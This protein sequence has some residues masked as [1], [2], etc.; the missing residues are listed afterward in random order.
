MSGLPCGH[1]RRLERTAVPAEA[2]RPAGARE[3]GRRPASGLERRTEAVQHLA[4]HTA[5]HLPAVPSPLQ[6]P[7]PLQFLE[8]VRDGGRGDLQLVG[9]L[10]H[11]TAR[12][13]EAAVGGPGLLAAVPFV[14]DQESNEPQPMRVPECFEGFAEISSHAECAGSSLVRLF[15]SYQYIGVGRNTAQG[16]EG[17][18]ST[19]P[20]RGTTTRRASR[21]AEETGELEPHG[22]SLWHAYRRRWAT[23]RKH[24]PATDIAEAGGRAGPETLQEAY[25]QAGRDTMLEVVTGGGKLR[26]VGG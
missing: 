3:S 20:R 19:E 5:E 12:R 1:L 18:G 22:G 17:L 7:R 16:R 4:V 26:E 9:Q 24:L 14:L 25:R 8:V 6:Q 10:S 21:Q 11:V 13:I 15:D 2:A 23:V